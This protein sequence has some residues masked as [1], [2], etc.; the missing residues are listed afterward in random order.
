MARPLRVEFPDAIYHV[1]HRGL[2][3]RDIVRDDRDRRKWTAQPVRAFGARFGGV[4]GVVGRVAQCLEEDRSLAR[5]V[6]VCEKPLGPH[7]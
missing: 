6:R 2:E 7:L 1:T 5:G 3:R 4:S